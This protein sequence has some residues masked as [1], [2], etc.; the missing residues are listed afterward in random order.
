MGTG[1]TVG[2]PAVETVETSAAEAAA[3][4]VA[5]AATIRK[6]EGEEEENLRVSHSEDES[7]FQER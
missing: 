1:Q 5:A 4:A 7:F 6:K 3:P 2:A